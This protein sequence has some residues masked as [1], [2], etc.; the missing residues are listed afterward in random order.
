MH[1]S[2]RKFARYAGFICLTVFLALSAYLIFWGLL[3]RLP[4]TQPALIDLR[5]D[6][7]VENPLNDR[8]FMICAGLANNPHGYPGHC[9]IIWDRC[10]PE[11]LEYAASDGFVPGHVKDLIPSLFTDINGFM[12][13]DALFGNM[14]NF[15]F[16]AVRLDRSRY[17]KARA[18][19]QKFVQDPTFHT[20]LRDCVTYVDEIAQI[21]GLRTSAH[22]FVYPLDYLEALKVLNKPHGQPLSRSS[23]S[24]TKE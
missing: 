16:L 3:Y 6:K 19:R 11:R 7:S 18:V 5:S 23:E 13:D 17:E 20:G 21:A 15:D 24:N 4:R 10:K 12:A 2:S 22:K 8:C 1:L 9:Y 14:R